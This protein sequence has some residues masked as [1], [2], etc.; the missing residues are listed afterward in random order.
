M[1]TALTLSPHK[2]KEFLEAAKRR[3]ASL[4]PAPT[5][6]AEREQLLARI[7]EAVQILKSEFGVSRV[8]LFGSLAHAAWYISDS[9]VDLAVEGLRDQDFFRAWLLVESVIEDREVDL[10]DMEMAS[11]SLRAAIQRTGIE[12]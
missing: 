3:S 10:V 12:L 8:I 7:R 6:V 5:E 1:T 2:R 9:D 11:E 4:E